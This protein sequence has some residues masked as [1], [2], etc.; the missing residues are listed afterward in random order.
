MFSLRGD[1]HSRLSVFL[2]PFQTA[3][4]EFVQRLYLLV[5]FLSNMKKEIVLVSLSRLL[6]WKSGDMH[7]SC[8]LNQWHLDLEYI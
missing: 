4:V 3:F 2:D 5:L 7:N 8:M 6:I 1:L